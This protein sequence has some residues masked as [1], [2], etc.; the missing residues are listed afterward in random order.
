MTTAS[1]RLGTA[2][3]LLIVVPIAVT[4][5]SSER[6]DVQF[7]LER[8]IE[9]SI[10]L[11]VRFSGG[12]LALLEKINRVDRDHLA[13]LQELVV[14]EP[15]TLDERAYVNLP[16]RHE[17]I[18]RLPK[19]L[20]VHLPAQ[21]FGAYEL[22]VL[23][24]WGPVSSGARASPTP[25]GLFHLNWRSL[26][27][28]SSVNPAWFLRWYFNFGNREGLAFHQYDLPGGPASHGC[29]RMLERD[30][31]FLFDWGDPWTLERN[32]NGIATTGTLVWI[33]GQYDFAAPPP[34]R[35]VAWL[36]QSLRLPPFPVAESR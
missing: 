9:Q 24:R 21:M 11:S 10:G 16:P 28:A 33:I 12:Q 4:S 22:G 13:D 2:L 36:S 14:P 6:Q 18:E 1:Q 19:L 26:G 5:V 32:G 20:L 17:P 8:P 34:W 31:R 27:H 15:L 29:V 7:R 3:V 35:S 30:A 23:V 25:S